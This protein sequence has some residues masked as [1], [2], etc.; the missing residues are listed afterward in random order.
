MIH[1]AS[2]FDKKLA[3][4]SRSAIKSED[5]LVSK[6]YERK[7]LTF[8]PPS[9]SFHIGNSSGK[10]KNSNCSEVSFRIFEKQETGKF[11]MS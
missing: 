9:I 3:S 8:H 4:S 11:D 6:V 10:I 5:M 2:F 7:N 1:R